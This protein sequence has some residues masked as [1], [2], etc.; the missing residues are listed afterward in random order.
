MKT[1]LNLYVLAILTAK[2]IS[3]ISMV[4]NIPYLQLTLYI[5]YKKNE[6]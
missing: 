3:F 6:R 1:N 2:Y 4:E 5:I